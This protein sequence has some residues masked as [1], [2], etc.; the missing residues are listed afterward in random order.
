MYMKKLIAILLGGIMTAMCFGGCEK[1]NEFMKDAYE[2]YFP[3][4]AAVAQYS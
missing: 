2:D 1:K 4:G 3:I